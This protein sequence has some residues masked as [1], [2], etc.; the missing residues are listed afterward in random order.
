[1]CS[2]VRNHHLRTFSP[3]QYFNSDTWGIMYWE[4]MLSG[5]YTND[6]D[7]FGFGMKRIGQKLALCRAIINSLALRKQAK[8][9][10]S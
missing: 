6:S 4:I 3:I 8:L 5:I 9:L 1:M 7:S 10:F 2:T